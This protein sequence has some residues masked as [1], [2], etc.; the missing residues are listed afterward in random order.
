MDCHSNKQ[1]YFLEHLNIFILIKIH[2]IMAKNI[3]NF[4]NKKIAILG[5]LILDKFTEGVIE[6]INPDQTTSP[7]VKI[8][9]EKFILG[10]AANVANNVFSLGGIPT[11]YG[12]LG[13]DEN[14]EIFSELCKKNKIN[15]KKV[16][17][18]NPTICKQRI[19]ADKYQVARMDFGE[20]NIKKIN[21]IVQN[22]I[23]KQLKNDVGKFDAVV[24]S[25]YN[26]LTF[27]KKF[28]QNIIEICRK[29]NIPTIVDPK[30]ENIL[31]FQNATVICPNKT[32]AKKISGEK[33]FT[34]PRNYL[35]SLQEL[36]KIT[37]AKY[38]I[39]TCGDQGVIALDPNS[40]ELI[41]ID[42][43]AKSVRDVTGAGDTFAATLALGFASKM[44]FKEI[45][46]LANIAAGIVVEKSGTATVDYLE[47]K[48]KIKADL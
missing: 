2:K 46:E 11:L 1:A 42:T 13:K 34:N 6:R 17:C 37:N 44:P 40:N 41:I 22:K 9:S 30:P 21:T 7:L 23:L 38:N 43:I 15:F 4:K 3:E 12:V 20:N 39:V 25:D 32:E 47:L 45:L 10:G 18:Q 26:K 8:K 48:D 24:L 14:A 31:F 33:Y 36:K 16:I 27:T 35:E 29:K 19:I 28:T 5:D